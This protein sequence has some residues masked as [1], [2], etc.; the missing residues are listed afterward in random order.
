[1]RKVT[2]IIAEDHPLVRQGIRGMLENQP[3][4]HV[5]GEADNGIEALRL[6]EQLSPDVFIADVVM[7]GMTGIEVLR[8]SRRLNPQPRAVFLSLYD[9][10]VYVWSALRN[11]AS[12]YILKHSAAE[13]L[14]PAIR[15]AL[16]G[17]QYL[18]PNLSETGLLRVNDMAGTATGKPTVELTDR[19]RNVLNLLADG[20]EAPQI[21]TRFSMQTEET[22]AVVND[23]VQRFGLENRHDLVV[24]A[25]KR[26]F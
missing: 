24:M 26:A 12:A 7:P 13:H 20:L 19:E 8:H 10:E 3:N 6:I 15:A 9:N 21:A 17:R 11:G 18:F 25:Q 23:L 2:L 1:M 22:N 5:V 16:E 4:F 14:V